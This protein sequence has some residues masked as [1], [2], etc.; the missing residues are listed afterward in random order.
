[1][2]KRFNTGLNPLNH[3]L[4][5]TSEMILPTKL[6]KFL[7]RH[8]VKKTLESCSYQI[9]VEHPV[10]MKVMDPI[11]NLIQ[12]RLYHPS[13]ELHWF[14]VCLR[15]S[16]ELDDMLWSTESFT[17]LFSLQSKLKS[18]S[19][20]S[21]RRISIWSEKASCWEEVMPPY[22]V[23]HGQISVSKTYLHAMVGHTM[24]NPYHRIALCTL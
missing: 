6:L 23:Y 22:T 16:V 19:M 18:C 17:Y 12:Q 3:N 7:A 1:M 14:L 13:R 11:Q 5:V 9:P 24:D 8:C 2:Q 4:H 20:F 10:G 21:I 15:C